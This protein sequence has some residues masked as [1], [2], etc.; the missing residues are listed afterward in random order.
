MARPASADACSSFLVLLLV[1]LVF[2]CADHRKRST[3]H[4]TARRNV[5]APSLCCRQRVVS[6]GFRRNVQRT[7]THNALQLFKRKSQTAYVGTTLKRTHS[8]NPHSRHRLPGVA[9][10]TGNIICAV[11]ALAK[12]PFTR[13]A[14]Q[15]RAP[16]CAPTLKCF[17][18]KKCAQQIIACTL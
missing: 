15:D 6:G 4:S 7:I 18:L 8:D 16:A 11:F 17:D 10:D 5:W 14:F 9:T 13:T 2:E 3:R 1:V 12:Q